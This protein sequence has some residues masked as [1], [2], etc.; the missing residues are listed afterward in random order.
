MCNVASATAE[1]QPRAVAVLAAADRSSVF[2]ERQG[3]SVQL[4][5]GVR[6]GLLTERSNVER[7][8]FSR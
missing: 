8:D 6:R 7:P 3:F 5:Q 1:L 4:R 2:A